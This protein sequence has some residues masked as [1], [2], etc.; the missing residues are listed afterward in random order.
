ME[1]RSPTCDACTADSS[2][3][4]PVWTP[5]ASQGQPFPAKRVPVEVWGIGG[6]KFKNIQGISKVKGLSPWSI[7]CSFVDMHAM[8]PWLN[9][10][11]DMPCLCQQ[12]TSQ[13]V[14]ERH[15]GASWLL[16]H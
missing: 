12:H 5:S 7:G 3:N 13:Q 4:W 6:F 8:Q 2:N 14:L 16:C 1:L 10:A 9:V 15:F 11:N